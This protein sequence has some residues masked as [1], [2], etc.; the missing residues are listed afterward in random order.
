MLLN[1]MLIHGYLPDDLMLTHIIPIVKNK[2]GDIT[3]KDNYRP[4]A[5]SSVLS[6][7]F[8]LILIARY[9][10][11]LDTSHNQFGYKEKTS[12][13]SCIFVLKEIV[14]Y[15]RRLSS[16]VYICF[17]D[18]SKAFDRINHYHLFKKL[19]SKGLPKI[20][21]RILLAWYTSQQFTVK[22]DNFQSTHFKS[23]NGVR[24]G[25]VLSPKLFNIF[26]DDLSSNLNNLQVGC[27]MNNVSFNHLFYADDAVIL[28]PSAK[29]L[30]KLL[31]TCE[32]FAKNNEIIFNPNKTYC[33]YL[34][35]KSCKSSKLPVVEINK[36]P[37]EWIE[38]HKYLGFCVNNCFNDNDDIDRQKKSLYAIGNTIIRKFIKCSEE[39]KIHLF[40]S[41]CRNL[42]CSS[43]WT[44]FKCKNLNNCRVAFNNIFR[45]LL[46]IKGRC[47]I[48][49]IFLSH[50]VDNFNI[51]LR[52]NI[53][54]FKTRLEK[55]NNSL[56]ACILNSSYFTFASECF[57]SW[58]RKLFVFN[59]SVQ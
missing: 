19:L 11:Y 22:W 4:I 41:F 29:G 54:S 20:I 42:Y 35:H 48:S 33:M 53:F 56:V 13:E 45:Y 46:N 1:S 23:I 25:S 17:L 47:S 24:Q 59:R 8:E 40:Q 57:N 51:I 16:N 2:K 15:Y 14:N 58:T 52:K 36:M 5:I 26:L 55:S 44:N 27:H 21:V 50:N 28:S 34:Q 9:S 39:V 10:D 31:T 3:S 32:N 7:V 12:S 18:A 49:E 38:K 43:L 37:L 30:Q 6:K